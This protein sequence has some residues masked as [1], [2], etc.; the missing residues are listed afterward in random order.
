M[1]V[2][3]QNLL[4]VTMMSVKIADLGERSQLSEMSDDISRFLSSIQ[5]DFIH[6]LSKIKMNLF[7]SMQAFF[8]WIDM[9]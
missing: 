7:Q 5:I 4:N 8:V 9:I 1:A 2:N 6:D 3:T